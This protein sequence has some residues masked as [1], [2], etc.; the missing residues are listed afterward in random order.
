[1]K[2]PLV[3]KQNTW[4][5]EA[6]GIDVS[7]CEMVT[8]FDQDNNL[9]TLSVKLDQDYIISFDILGIKKQIELLKG[10]EITLW[11]HQM[12]SVSRLIGDFD[13]ARLQLVQLSTVPDLTHL[14]TIAEAK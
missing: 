3:D 1:M 14:M 2:N 5:I 7:S 13:L 4:I 8:K 9:R 11:R 12:T 6:L 10:E